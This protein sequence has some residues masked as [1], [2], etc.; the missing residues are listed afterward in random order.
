MNSNSKLREAV[1]S[2]LDLLDDFAITEEIVLIAHEKQLYRETLHTDKTLAVLRRAKAALAEP[3]RN[4]DVFESESEMQTA[5]LDYYNEAF[6]LKGT[7]Y[8]IEYYDLNHNVD[9]I[10]YDYIRWLLTPV[11]SKMEGENNGN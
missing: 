11:E 10:L 4:C 5:F 9:G 2:L 3:L 8:E 7:S 1:E 6:S